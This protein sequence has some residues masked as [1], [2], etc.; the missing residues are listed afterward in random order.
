VKSLVLYMLD[1]TPI[2]VYT[3]RAWTTFKAHPETN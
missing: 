3:E 2:S 1:Q